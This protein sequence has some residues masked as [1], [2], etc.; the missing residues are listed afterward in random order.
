MAP[1]LTAV[2]SGR[3]KPSPLLQ[4]FSYLTPK[5]SIQVEIEM[6]TGH[7]ETYKPPTVQTSTAN[8]TSEVK[9]D[10]NA[11]NLSGSH[12]YKLSELAYLRSG[13]K[14]D[15]CNIGVIARSPEI[16]P[17]LKARLTDDVIG[18]YF[19]HKFSPPGYKAG[20]CE[21]YELPGV[22]ALNF[23][24]KNSLGGGGIASLTPDPQGKGYAQ[25]LADLDLQ[26][27][28]KLI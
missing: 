5:D 7:K 26:K 1:G 17:I 23:V 10:K 9:D 4:F 13:D 25:Q 14:G 12:S 3:P 19:Q 22:F 6:S 21:R 20:F 15:T 27:L 28:P 11:D 8:L 16:Y 24:L 18:Q 2:V